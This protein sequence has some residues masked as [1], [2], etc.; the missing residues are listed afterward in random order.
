MTREHLC[1]WGGERRGVSAVSARSARGRSWPGCGRVGS[2]MACRMLTSEEGA[3]RRPAGAAGRRVARRLLRGGAVRA[4]RAVRRPR[5]RDPRPG[6]DRPRAPA[7]RAAG[8]RHDVLLP[9]DQGPRHRDPSPRRPR[10][11]RDPRQGHRPDRRGLRGHQPQAGQ[12]ADRGRRDLA[13]HG[14]VRGRP[15]VRPA[16]HPRPAASLR[17]AGRYDLAGHAAGRDHPRWRRRA[18]PGARRVHGLP[19]HPGAELPGRGLQPAPAHRGGAAAST[20]AATRRSRTT[21]ATWTR[22]AVP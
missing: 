1:A 8:E 13:A 19:D 7:R 22:S 5:R 20:T 18:A 9:A 12:P 6:R 17:R 15:A 3:T 14:P 21:Y 10:D 2:S 11:D 16:R 4:H